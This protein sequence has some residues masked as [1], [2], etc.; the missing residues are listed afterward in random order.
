[1]NRVVWLSLLVAGCS[2]VAV[3]GQTLPALTEEVV[4]FE[5]PIAGGGATAKLELAAMGDVYP[6]DLA[7]QSLAAGIDFHPEAHVRY[8]APVLGGRAA[9][10]FVPYLQV[11]LR[12][13]NLDNGQRLEG[14]LLPGFGLRDGW[15]YMADVDLDGSIGLSAA[16]YL[17]VLTI[18]PA[19]G[20]VLHEDLLDAREGTF[21]GT[22]PLT[23]SGYFT[24]EDLAAPPTA[25]EPAEEPAPS[26]GYGY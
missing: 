9:G 19:E 14:L 17:A 2:E 21:L 23:A 6:A 22:E 7:A 25:E 15:H 16:G 8:T 4:L 18:D 20:V 24:L 5:R 26:M 10:D 3:P 13:E 11:T 12:L 1:M